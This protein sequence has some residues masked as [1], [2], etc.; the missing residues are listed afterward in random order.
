MMLVIFLFS[1]LSSPPL[2]LPI[3]LLPPPLGLL[4]RCFHSDEQWLYIQCLYVLSIFAM[5]LQASPHSPDKGNPIM[6]DFTGA[7]RAGRGF[8]FHLSFYFKP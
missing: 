2:L 6:K 5:S 8:S 4:V 7:P 1:F 3:T